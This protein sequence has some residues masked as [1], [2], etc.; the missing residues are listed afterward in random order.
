[1]VI[2]TSEAHYEANSNFAG[3][4][5][6]DTRLF[7]SLKDPINPFTGLCK[8]ASKTTG[9]SNSPGTSRGVQQQTHYH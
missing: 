1:M 7:A 2:G 9:Q 8:Q 6:T 3:T 4:P 5:V